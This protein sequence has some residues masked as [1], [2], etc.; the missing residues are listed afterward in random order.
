MKRIEL[1]KHPF[2]G[3]LPEVHRV[4]SIGEWLL[5]HYGEV[6]STNVYV[7][8][9]QPSQAT[10]ITG[11]VKKILANDEDVYTILEAP[12]LPVAAAAIAEWLINFAIAAVLSAIVNSIFAADTAKTLDN[13]AQESPNNQLSSRDNKVRLMERVEEIFG[14][15]RAIP[16]IMMQTYTKFINNRRVEYGLYCVTR[17][18][19][20]L[21]D[22]RDGETLLS[23]ITGASAAVY[24]PFTSPNSSD[25]PVMQIGDPIIDGVVN[26]SS[27][28]TLDGIV[29]KAANQLQLTSPNEYW[30]RGPS[31]S[32]S[33]IGSMH[34]PPSTGDIIYQNEAFRNPNFSAVAE[35]GQQ[36]T[37]DT[38][39]FTLLRSFTNGGVDAATK[40][41]SFF[42]GE[43]IPFH[44]LVNG[45]SINIAGFT[46]PV[47]NGIKTVASHTDSSFTVVEACVTES[48]P[49]SP[50]DITG[51]FRYAGTRTM[52]VVGNGYAELSGTADISGPTPINVFAVT[53][54][55]DNDLADWTDWF[56][57]P[58]EDRTEVWVNVAA[59]QGMFK[60][61]GGNRL[62]TSVAYEVQIEQLTVGTLLPTGVVETVGGSVSGATANERGETLEHVTGW[63]GPAR[64]RAR[65]STPYD[66]DF[67]GF[68]SDE[69]TWLVLNSVS[70]VTKNDFGNKTI[71][72]TVTHTTPQAAAVQRRQLNCRA[73]RLI[74]TYDGATFSGAFDANGFLMTGTIHPSKRMVD[75]LA[76]VT[77]D[78]M[79]GNR[80]IGDLDMAQVWATQLALNAWH[81]EAGN[82]CYTFDRD[83]LSYEETVMAIANAVFCVGYRQNSVIRL[84]LD[85]PQANSIALFTHR[86]KKPDSETITRRFS[87]D[88]DYD[89]IELSYMDPDTESMET[90]RLP[91]GGTFTKLKRVEVTGLCSFAAAWFR[92][93]REYARLFN[94]RL[95]IE[96]SVTVD[97]RAVL[98]NSRVEITD[99]TRFRTWDGEVVA[100]AGLE[101]TLSRDVEFVPAEPHSIVLKKRDGSQ[102]SLGVTAGSAPNKVLLAGAP[103]EALVVNP[104]P[105]SGVRT[106]FSLAAD[107]ARL[108]QSWLVQE[109]SLEENGF[110]RLVGVNYSDAYYAVDD[111]PVPPRDSV[112]N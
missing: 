42:G 3:G 81:P 74:P 72:H 36:L 32:E 100:Q 111:D 48:V 28:S 17:G 66:Y 49:G 11:N 33:I 70:P 63:V 40:T 95:S 99:S 64:V 27:S 91:A 1:Y 73:A 59:L 45:T 54:T 6:P 41:Y 84:A 15:V 78:P 76:A 26:V 97:A 44:G 10:S 14:E 29:L 50:M 7:Y 105:E 39:N 87:N 88:S 43:S 103:P 30:V 23:S 69:I 85:R 16:S 75:I 93:N 2:S 80:D 57:L 67:D 8:V 94:E 38:G 112:I 61:D 65:R 55:V 101:L 108:A 96:T 109:L 107:V 5:E 22:V 53:A 51:T 92:A 19:A 31:A 18:Y 110:V 20:A 4:E 37:Y 79:I 47:N 9:G 62:G 90:I 35:A 60:D 12:G 25:P 68:V 104:T 77:M 106:T 46:D 98:P 86:N 83:N 102:M 71:V 82:F 56:T 34:I 58:N 21:S 13:R 52:T 89:G 24:Y